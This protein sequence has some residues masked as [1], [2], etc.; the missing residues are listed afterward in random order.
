MFEIHSENKSTFGMFHSILKHAEHRT[1]NTYTERLVYPNA[2]SLF[3][4]LFF[5]FSFRTEWL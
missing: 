1:L 4:F 2:V 3:V 5:F